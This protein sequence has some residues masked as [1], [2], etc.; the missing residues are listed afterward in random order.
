PPSVGGERRNCSFVSSEPA[1]TI[2]RHLDGE[3]HYF[4]PPKTRRL[5]SGQ[6]ALCWVRYPS[7]K[8]DMWLGDDARL[9]PWSNEMRV[10]MHRTALAGPVVLAAFLIPDLSAWAS[11]PFSTCR[12]VWRCDPY[13]ACA[14]YRVCPRCC[15]SR[16]AC[17][18]LYGAYGPYGGTG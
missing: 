12:G 15:P 13:G 17:S 11:D 14:W 16:Y 18:S 10:E 7:C 6:W 9:K 8:F 5:G 2:S 4:R 1:A 3:R